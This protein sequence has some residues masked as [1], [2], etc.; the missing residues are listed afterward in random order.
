MQMQL[1]KNITNVVLLSIE[2][3]ALSLSSMKISHKL[4]FHIKTDKKNLTTLKCEITQAS[5]PITNYFFL[6]IFIFKF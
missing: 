4:T 5:K 2:C 6:C 3:K 1:E